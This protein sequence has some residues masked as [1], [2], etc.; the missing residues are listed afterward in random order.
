MVDRRP[1]ALKL[2]IEHK[3]PVAEDALPA[4]QEQDAVQYVEQD[5]VHQMK[6][7]V[8]SS[9]PPVQVPNPVQPLQTQVQP[10]QPQLNWS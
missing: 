7:T 5:P 3:S 1:P 10:G 2:P 9:A 8:Q 4:Q 6:K